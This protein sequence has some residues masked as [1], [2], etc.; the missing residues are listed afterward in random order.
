MSKAL[1]TGAGGFIGSHLV[2]RLAAEGYSVRALYRYNSA[3]SRGWLDQVPGG[4][5]GN[6]EA[7]AGD[8]RDP[9]QVAGLVKGVDVVFHLAALIGIPYSYAAPASYVETNVGGTLNLLMACMAAGG[10][11]FVHTST[12]EVYGTARYTPMDEGHLQTAQSPYSATKIA[13]DRLVESYHLSYGLETV[14]VRPFNT[15]GPRQSAR[16]VIPTVIRQALAGNREIR[17]GALDPV[18]DFNFVQ[19]TVEGF[20]AASLSGKAV[21]RVVNLGTGRGVS[22]GQTV[23]MILALCGS[24]AEVVLDEDRIRPAQSEVMALVADATLAGE[25]LGWAPGHTLEQGLEK[26]IAWT[27]SQA[28]QDRCE[29]YVV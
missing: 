14:T 6:V 9:F 15:Y 11:R 4:L 21:G 10:K 1:V 2:E 7:V 17:L 26:T 25:L 20:L 29:G 5:P 16:A 23:Q 24:N 13:A 12:S 18:R 22:V 8:I 28:G 27:R 19:D 3:N